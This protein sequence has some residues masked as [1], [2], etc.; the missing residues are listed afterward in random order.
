MRAAHLEAARWSASH[1]LMFAISCAYL[2]ILTACQIPS[3]SRVPAAQTRPALPAAPAQA[4]HYTIRSDLSDVRFL[5]YRA[6]PLAARG[7][8]HVVQAKTITG[9]IY[10]SPEF[11]RSTFSIVMPVADFV[12]DSAEA[13]TVEGEE[14]AKLPAPEF[15]EGTTRNMMG[16]RVLDATQF[17][18]IE[19]RTV[20]V[21]GPSWAPDVTIRIRLKGAERDIAVPVA[22][23]YA[24]DRLVAI[25]VF[26]VKQTDFGISPLSILG[27][28][29]QVADAIRVRMRIAAQKS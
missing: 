25:T 27:G 3:E 28:A 13:R 29:L 16:S 5:V 2:V 18:Q 1:V 24:N 12:V 26:E 19:I 22:I 9:D 10:L 15:I 4:T 6:G 17:P 8:N 7:H 20:A 14:F 21:I 23:D 11:Q